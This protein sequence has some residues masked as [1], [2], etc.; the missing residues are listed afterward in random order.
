MSRT[1][2][3]CCGN[4][5]TEFVQFG[6]ADSDTTIISPDEVG[7]GLLEL[8]VCNDCGSAI[9]NIL[10]VDGRQLVPPEE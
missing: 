6:G 8:R 3:P 5:D 10:R 9:E 1:Y 7:D 2:C 4:E